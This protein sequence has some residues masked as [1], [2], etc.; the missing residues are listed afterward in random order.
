MAGRASAPVAGGRGGQRYLSRDEI[1]AI[2][3]AP[4]MKKNI[5]AD[6]DVSK[7]TVTHIKRGD[8]HLD[9]TT[10]YRIA[11]KVNASLITMACGVEL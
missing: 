4:G 3:L 1:I 2:Y 7:A 5:A 6:F 11:A 8:R 10:P 9:I